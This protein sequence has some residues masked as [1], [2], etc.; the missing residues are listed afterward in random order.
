MI[1]HQKTNFPMMYRDMD[2]HR[3]YAPFNWPNPYFIHNTLLKLPVMARKATVTL[4]VIDSL[5]KKIKSLLNNTLQKVSF[6]NLRKEM[7]LASSYLFILFIA[8]RKSFINYEGK[9]SE[10]TKAPSFS[11]K[12]T[13]FGA[14]RLRELENKYNQNN[15]LLLLQTTRVEI[16]AD[17]SGSHHITRIVTRI[18]KKI[19]LIIT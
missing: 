2:V 16:I 15:L 1:S 10:C 13:Q 17:K 4:N 5:A 7:Y 12:T 14:V 19:K 9:D 18:L 6:H 3:V 11:S 8:F